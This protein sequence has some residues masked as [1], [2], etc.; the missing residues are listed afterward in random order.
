MGATSRFSISG[1]RAAQ[2]RLFAEQVTAEYRVRTEGRGRTVDEWKLPAH[3]LDKHWFGCVVGCATGASI[4]DAEL[5][6]TGGGPARNQSRTKLS[7]L[8]KARQQ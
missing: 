2:H 5:Q 8:Q 4:Q 3:R 1:Q 6:G 7:V